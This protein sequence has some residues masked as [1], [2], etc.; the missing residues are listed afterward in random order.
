MFD[1]IGQAAERLVTSVSR[2]AFLGRLG[3]AALAAAGAAAGVFADPGKA[4]A[5]DGSC[6]P[7]YVKRDCWGVRRCCSKYRSGCISCL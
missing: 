3:Q 1:T 6:P 5:G 4:R 7:G 2:R